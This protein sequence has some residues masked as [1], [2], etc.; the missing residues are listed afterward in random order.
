MILKKLCLI[1]YRNYEY[2]LLQFS[3]R[4]NIFFG[5]NAQGKTNLLEAVNFIS[6]GNSFKTSNE[7]DLIKFGERS[8]Y[9]RAEIEKN[10][11]EKIVEAKLSMVDRKRMRI[12]EVEIENLKELSNQFEIVLFSPETLQMIKDSPHF[13]RDFIDDLIIG[14]DPT[15]KKI[16][17]EYNKILYQRNNLLKSRKDSWFEKELEALNQ[18]I[19]KSGNEIVKK[20]KILISEVS[21]EAERVHYKLTY[22]HEKLSVEYETNCD[23]DIYLSLKESY[24]KDIESGSTNI[25]PHRDDLDIK[26][27]GISTRKFAS[28]GQARTASISFKLAELRILEKYNKTA[29]ILLLDDVFSELDQRRIYDLLKVVNSY[30]TIVTTNE[31]P[32]I[33]FKDNTLICRIHQGKVYTK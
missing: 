12:N 28:Q 17:K 25:G 33:N 2:E 22:G 27:N 1:N 10:G 29:P 16:I 3:P 15:Y 18:Q 4:V 14:I 26:I 21:D 20:R 6:K 11:V 9:I 8:A 19:V 31:L 24:L 7:K 5:K 13:R 23:N 32:N 30:Q